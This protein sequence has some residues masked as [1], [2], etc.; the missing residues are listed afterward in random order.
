MISSV[1]CL[2]KFLTSNGYL[3][4]SSYKRISISDKGSLDF[5]QVGLDFR[6]GG[7]HV[8]QVGLDV[9]LD[10]KQVKK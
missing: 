1:K 5:R 8:G 10:F 7:F 4:S 9:G 3:L 6:Q 2:S